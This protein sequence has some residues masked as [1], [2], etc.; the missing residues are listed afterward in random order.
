MISNLRKNCGFW[1]TPKITL[2][3]PRNGKYGLRKF[4]KSLHHLHCRNAEPPIIVAMCFR[5]KIHRYFLIKSELHQQVVYL[6]AFRSK[7]QFGVSQ[8]TLKKT[9]DFFAMAEEKKGFPNR[10]PFKK[11]SFIERDLVSIS[12]V[13]KKIK[14]TAS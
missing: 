11:A 2:V 14:K 3:K 9:P 6:A 1:G 4:K 7:S 10:V 8:K 12:R 13:P 5:S